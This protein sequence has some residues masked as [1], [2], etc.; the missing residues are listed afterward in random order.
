MRAN[1]IGYI[2]QLKVMYKVSKESG[3][4]DNTVSPTTAATA[5]NVYRMSLVH[6]VT[7]TQLLL[8]DSRKIQ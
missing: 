5:E 4:S 8:I 2:N 6:H 3:T 7:D 1:I